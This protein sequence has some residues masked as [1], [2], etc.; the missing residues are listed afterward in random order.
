MPLNSL[1]LFF[2][3]LSANLEMTLS[4]IVSSVYSFTRTLC[5]SFLSFP[6][7]CSAN[8]IENNMQSSAKVF[9]KNKKAKDSCYTSPCTVDSNQ[10]MQNDPLRS[11]PGVVA[12]TQHFCFFFLLCRCCWRRPLRHWFYF[13]MKRTIPTWKKKENNC[14][15]VDTRTHAYTMPSRSTEGYILF[16]KDEI[17]SSSFTP[18]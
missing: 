18:V 3:I 4:S 10:I 1:S 17:S 8:N 6:L 13:Q 14:T 16:V 5:L 9:W 12:V 15:L 7:T 11:R 2:L